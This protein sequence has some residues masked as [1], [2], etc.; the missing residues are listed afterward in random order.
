M[1]TKYTNGTWK[2][3]INGNCQTLSVSPGVDNEKVTSHHRHHPVQSRR[4]L[5][6]LP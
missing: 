6:F 5:F 4:I 2:L 3:A 1:D